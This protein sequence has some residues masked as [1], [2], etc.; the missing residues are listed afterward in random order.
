MTDPGRP[1]EP[2]HEQLANIAMNVEDD[3]V[4]DRLIRIARQVRA[5]ER[6]QAP[7]DAR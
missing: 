6:G 2:L 4:A 7:R 1:T 5:L 3:E